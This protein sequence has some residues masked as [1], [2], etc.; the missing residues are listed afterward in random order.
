M[1]SLCI[2]NLYTPL[3]SKI[4]KAVCNNL[5]CSRHL[6]IAAVKATECKE[7]KSIPSRFRKVVIRNWLDWHKRLKSNENIVHI[8]TIAKQPLINNHRTRYKTNSYK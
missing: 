1:I 5:E 8:Y 4:V 7:L 2:E 3:S 6:S